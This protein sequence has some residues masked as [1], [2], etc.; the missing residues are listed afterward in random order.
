MRK[1]SKIAVLTVVA[2]FFVNIVGAQER[3]NLQKTLQTARANNPALRTEKYNVDI[4]KAD[5]I[6]AGL[7]P[8]LS[9]NNQTIQLIQPSHFAPNTRWADTRNDQVWFQLT[10]EFQL[11]GQRK[12]KIDFANKSVDLTQKNYDE[13]ERNILFNVANKWL[14]VWKN[15]M[16]LKMI[17]TAKDNIDSLVLT[18][19]IRFK[20]QVINQTDLSR[21][22][23]L[24]KQYDIQYKTVSQEYINS[25]KELK[26]MVGDSSNF[27]IDTTDHFLYA[28]A[29]NLDSLISQ[30]MQNRSDVQAAKSLVEVTNSNIKLQKS[31]AAPD[32]EFGVI[33][34]PQ[35][36]IQYA[37]IYATIE[38]PVFDRNQ[39][40]IKKSQ[41]LNEQ[42]KQN[43][44]LTQNRLQTEVTNAYNSYKLQQKNMEDFANVINESQTILENVKYAYL[45]GGT[46][47]ID[48]LEAQRSW[49]ETQQNYYDAM[50]LYRKSFL[51]LIYETGLINQLAQ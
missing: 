9:L 42:G 40:E 5:V 37:G 22:E 16:Q 8:N 46:T 21:T 27:I 24:A 48:F 1:N 17:K 35:N 45:K 31:L 41:L 36:N 28:L 18:N 15:A 14:E 34:N 6:T 39:G 4:A 7:R 32:F 33:Y 2:L 47:I 3:Y 43:L 51:Q 19:Q 23:L 29:P 13:T 12:N 26:L 11:G 10:K 20:D 38:L 30:S 49:L 44:E 50:E 25:Q